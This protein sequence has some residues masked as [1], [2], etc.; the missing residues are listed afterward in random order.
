MDN[1]IINNNIHGFCMNDSDSYNAESK[2]CLSRGFGKMD[3][4]NY[5][6]FIPMILENTIFG[7]KKLYLLHSIYILHFIIMVI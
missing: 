7:K 3:L 6:D 4:C 1:Y 2:R 5:Y